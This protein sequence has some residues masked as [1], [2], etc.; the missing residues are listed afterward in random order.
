MSDQK[1]CEF[2]GE[3]LKPM[4]V[5]LLYGTPI[6][7]D[8]FKALIEARETLFPNANSHFLGGCHLGSS[9][10]ET[11]ALVCLQCREAEEEWAESTGLPTEPDIGGFFIAG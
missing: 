7:N 5:P 9:G 3:S 10:P 1:L 11:E 6:M 8:A 4:M 2:H